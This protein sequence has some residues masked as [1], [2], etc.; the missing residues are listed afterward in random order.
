ASAVYVWKIPEAGP[1]EFVGELKGY[2]GKV[3]TAGFSPD[4]QLFAVVS[5]LKNKG[6]VSLWRSGGWDAPIELAVPD[7]IG[8]L[9]QLAFCPTPSSNRLAVAVAPV[10]PTSG[11]DRLICLEWSLK[12]FR[13]EAPLRRYTSLEPFPLASLQGEIQTFVTYKPD[14]SMLLVSNSLQNSPWAYVWLFNSKKD[15]TPETPTELFQ[16]LPLPGPV[17]HAAFSPWDDRLVIAIADGNAVLWSSKSTGQGE[18][19]YYQ[20]NSFKHK[21]QIFKADFSPDGR[22]IVTASRDYRALVWD[23][24]SGELAYPSFHH[25]GSMTDAGFTDDGRSLIISSRDTIYR[26]DLTRGESRPLPLGT[27][28]G[29]RTTSADPEGNLLVTAGE[30]LTRREQ[31]GSAGWARVWDAVTGDPRS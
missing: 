13:V 29:V 23:A 17:L 19:R 5:Q 12:E 28:R 30:R 31:L 16:S 15:P 9:G 4:G 6:K 24:D 10:L 21:S 25:S 27:R 14:G 26:W 3:T 8:Q 2:E 1:E 18:K 22:Y 7:G 11:N 20:I